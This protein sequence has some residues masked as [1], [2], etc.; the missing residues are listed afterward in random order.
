MHL[1]DWLKKYGFKQS[2]WDPCL[3]T[4]TRT[5]DG[6]T[7]RCIVYVDDL[8]FAH[9]RGSNIRDEFAEAFSR[10]FSWKDFGTELHE[11]LSVRIT[12]T[13]GQTTLDM[14]RYISDMFDEFMPSG[15]HVDYQTPTT[16]DLENIVAD[17]IRAKAKIEPRLLQRY[18]RLVC[19]S[20]YAVTMVAAEAACVSLG[21]RDADALPGV[22]VPRHAA[23][24]GARAHLPPP[25]AR[26]GK[27]Q[28][29]VQ[30]DR[31]QDDGR[32]AA[33]GLL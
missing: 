4:Y 25:G 8:L 29:H 20:L 33:Q 19:M 17:A 2:E 1:R 30:A 7:L 28:D 23:R 13:A 22:P 32:A 16:P 3:Y 14:E 5:V 21:G 11:Y 6:H 10:D 12:Q 27:A 31:D 26:A 18:Q 15:S 24:G 9:T